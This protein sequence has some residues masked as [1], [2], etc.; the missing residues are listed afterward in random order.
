MR[1]V[2]YCY[3]LLINTRG[4]AIPPTLVEAIRQLASENDLQEIRTK[5]YERITEIDED[6]EVMDLPTGESVDLEWSEGTEDFQDNTVAQV[7]A[8][9]GLANGA[10]PDFNA[11]LDPRGEKTLWGDAEWFEDPSNEKIA[12]APRWHQLVGLLTM[13]DRAFGNRNVLLMDEVGLGK[14]MQIVGVIAILTFFREYYA[15]KG[16]FPGAFSECHDEPALRDRC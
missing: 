14:T 10:M 8:A 12:C 11:V 9:L 5:V 16:C 3:A 2:H 4:A 1:C 7:S 15:E 13:C 6:E